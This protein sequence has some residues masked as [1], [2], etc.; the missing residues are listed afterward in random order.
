MKEF[1]LWF[2]GV[3]LTIWGAALLIGSPVFWGLLL[4]GTGV[5]CIYEAS[6][7]SDGR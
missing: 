5:Y 4:A 1:L 2:V 6:K 3:V 7:L